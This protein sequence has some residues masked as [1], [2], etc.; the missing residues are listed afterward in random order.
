MLPVLPEVPVHS[1]KH[2]AALLG[3]LVDVLIWATA[4]ALLARQVKDQAS[5]TKFLD[6][7]LRNIDVHVQLQ[8]LVWPRRHAGSLVPLELPPLIVLAHTLSA[9][10]TA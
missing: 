8:L 9:Q 4:R 3:L 2:E 7:E 10:R 1:E 6:E 5:R